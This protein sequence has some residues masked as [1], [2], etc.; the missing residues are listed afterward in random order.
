MTAYLACFICA[1]ALDAIPAFAPPSW[2]ALVYLQVEYGL[3]V[4]PVVLLG[5]A[6]SSA[7]RLILTLYIHRVSRFLLTRRERSNIECLGEQLG[8]TPIADFLFV[9]LY[10]LTP[11]STSPLFLAAGISGIKRREIFPPFVLGKLFGYGLILYA[12]RRASKDLS[13]LFSGHFTWQA[14]AFPL[15]GLAAVA[16]LLLVDWRLLFHERKLRLE[17][18]VFHGYHR[19]C[20]HYAASSLSR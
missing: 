8:R 1:A 5:V 6:G 2:L 15:F 16:G 3:K 18:H 14:A 11:I 19:S 12:G 13:S 7:G 4:W 17:L 10:S 20:R 9:F